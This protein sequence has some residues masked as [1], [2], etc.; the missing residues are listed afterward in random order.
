LTDQT[1]VRVVAVGGGH[2][3][4]TTLR[5]ARQYAGDITAVVSV[6]DDGGSSGRLRE[7]FGVPAPGDL[8]KCLV[9]LGEPDSVWA[10]AFEH[11][12]EAG[13]LE[14]HALGNLVI[15]GLAA[16]TGSFIR[17]LEEAGRLVGATGRVL[18]ATTG[19]V[20]LKADVGGREVEG[21]VEVASAAATGSITQVSVVPADAESPPEVAVA[22][23]AADQ[24]VIGP[25]SLYT[26]VLAVCAVPAVRDAIAAARAT[27]VYVCNLHT[28]DG[29]T[30][31]FDAAAHVAALSAHGIHVDV[32]IHDPAHLPTGNVPV[33]LV[34]Q[35]LARPDGRAHDPVKL[36]GVL[37]HLVG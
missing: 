20:V 7:T 17:G 19:P 31:G 12:F 1:P 14:G 33:R 37:A 28:Q 24:I 27:K 34:Q 29:E 15:V 36:A 2:G 11:R 26:S 23:E 25:G 16:A 21:Q 30:V 35:P 9:A 32:V 6:A 8:R 5:A 18:P 10:V 22:I 3:L 4:A 13:E